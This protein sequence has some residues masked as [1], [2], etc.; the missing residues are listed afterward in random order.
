MAT[1]CPGLALQVFDLA[2]FPPKRTTVEALGPVDTGAT[3]WQHSSRFGAIDSRGVLPRFSRD[4]RLFCVVKHF[5]S[6]QVIDSS[7][8]RGRISQNTALFLISWRLRRP[9]EHP[10]RFFCFTCDVS[11]FTQS[12]PR[13]HTLLTLCLRSALPV[14]FCLTRQKVAVTTICRSPA[15]NSLTCALPHSL[16]L[17]PLSTRRFATMYSLVVVTFFFSAH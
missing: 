9:R 15:D 5:S 7:L 8:Y 12:L 6:H 2:T 10:L 3:G 14:C 17:N 1:H 13:S 11:L 16:L 4:R